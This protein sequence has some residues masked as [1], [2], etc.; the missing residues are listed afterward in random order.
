M[1]LW[2]PS[3]EFDEAVAAV[4]HGT[5]SEAQAR[6][7]NALLR[8]SAAARDEYLLRVELHSRLASAPDL[9]VSAS[10]GDEAL[11]SLAGFAPA[12]GRGAGPPDFHEATVTESAKALPRA[13]GR[14][15]RS[16]TCAAPWHAASSGTPRRNRVLVWSAALA[17]GLG[18]VGG[19]WKLWRAA[20]PTGRTSHAV[21]LLNQAVDA[22]W[23]PRGL[24]PRLGAPLEPGGLQ[25][26]SG[27]AQI[28]FYSGARVVIEGP[29]ELEVISPKEAFCRRGLLAA[30]VPPQASGFRVRT[31]LM[32][33]TDP[34]TTFA[35][36]VTNRRTELH[37][38]EG[39]VELQTAVGMAMQRLP[40]GTGV[41]VEQARPLRMVPANPAIFASLFDVQAKGLAAEALRLGQW[42]AAGEQLNRTPALLVRF[43]FENLDPGDWRLPNVSHGGGGVTAAT[44]VGCQWTEG[45]WPGKRALAFQNVSDRVRLNVPGEFESLTLAAW[46]RVQGLDRPLNS[47][48][49]TDGFEPGEVH[50]LIRNDGVLSLGVK[51]PGPGNFQIIASP[52]VLTLDQLG[53]WTHLAVVLDGDAGRAVHYVNGLAVGAAS[54]RLTPPYRLGTA[55]LGNWNPARFPG[56]DPWL[57]R[58]FSGA[59]DEFCLF[60]RALSADEIRALYAEGNPQPAPAAMRPPPQELISTANESN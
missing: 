23:D 25:L 38:F 52:R 21:A 12:A 49:M 50:W 26:K 60:S 42:R 54:L 1:N 47:L 53:L 29:A 35:L 45:R 51:G 34:G 13:I 55:E 2:F 9:F 14:Y 27:L 10:A 24:V 36:E 4:C 56:N 28:V 5:A 59:M 30:E 6:A 20:E 16:K 8:S 44:I 7:L 39:T 32:S 43:D 48:F 57:I 3:R 46:V 41:V 58:N 31:P 40:E 17:A 11:R 19:G 37:V 22:Q 18:L 15:R 33:V